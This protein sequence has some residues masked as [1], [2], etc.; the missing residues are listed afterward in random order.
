MK[1]KSIKAVIFSILA[2]LCIPTCIFCLCLP[3]GIPSLG[4]PIIMSEKIQVVNVDGNPVISGKLKNKSKVDITLETQCLVIAMRD[5]YA[6]SL[7]L[8]ITTR[9]TIVIEAGQEFDLSSVTLEYEEYDYLKSS[10]TWGYNYQLDAVTVYPDRQEQMLIFS[11][12]VKEEGEIYATFSAILGAAFALIALFP[13]ATYIRSKRR[14]KLAQPTLAKIG[15]GVFLR[16]AFC[17]EKG[18]NIKPTLF[19]K[20]K[21]GFKS[22]TMGVKIQTRYYNAEAMDFIITPKG[23]YIASAKNKTVD[24]G[25]MEFFDKEEL[26]KTQIYTY[27]VNVVLNPLF[28]DNYFAFDLSN[29][30]LSRD[31]V[32]QLLSQMFDNDEEIRNVVFDENSAQKNV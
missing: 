17:Q 29:S 22:L 26:D 31:E 27:K 18:L 8:H 15:D 9:D 20:I 1:F 7:Y 4:A 28:N 5:S 30:K 19:S 24:L 2:L 23:F 16:G 21:G 12:S 25:S 14:F 10:Y 3:M 13:I 32:A 11:K 6:G